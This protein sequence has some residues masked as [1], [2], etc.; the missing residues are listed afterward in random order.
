MDEFDFEELVAEMLDISDEERDNDD[1]YLVNKFYDKY[2]ID[3]YSAYKL[4]KNL[5]LHTIPVEAGLSHKHWYAF[6]SRK[7]P[8]MLMKIEKISS[9]T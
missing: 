2:E 7:Q 6:V 8:V 9:D 5:L 4:A 1:T 3:F